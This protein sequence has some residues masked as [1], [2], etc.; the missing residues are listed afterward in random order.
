MGLF[1]GGAFLLIYLVVVALFGVPALMAELALGRS[2]R[3]GPL[4]AFAGA[5]IPGGKVV[6]GVLFLGVGM[7]MSYYLV[8]VGW[9]L[10]YCVLAFLNLLGV[11]NNFSSDTF[12]WLQENWPLQVLCAAVV[13][14][15]SAEVV[16]R[17]VK[18]GIERAS[19]VFVPVFGVLMTLLAVR[20]LTLPGAWEGVRYLFTPEWENVTRRAV[21]SATGQAFFSLGLG[22]T[23]FVI[24]GSYLSDEESLARRAVGTAAG[25]IVASLLAAFA[26]N[27]RRIRHRPVAHQRSLLTLRGVAGRVFGDAGRP[28]VRCLVFRRAWMRRFLV[29]G[30]RR[31]GLGRL[32]HRERPV[33]TSQDLLGGVLGARR[34][35]SARY[36]VDRLPLHE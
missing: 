1:G 18:G 27:T 14:A 34:R 26:V 35:R 21:L 13:A 8:V 2:M 6:G 23:F 3:K 15:A 20:S 25:D 4:T 29:G 16:G 5:G 9:V 30:C 7:G 22:G 31:G 32:P 17:G 24:Y 11:S 33:V 28:R 19:T 12:A 36:V 10:A